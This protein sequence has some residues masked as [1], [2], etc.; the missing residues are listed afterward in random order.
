[1][2]CT[3]KPSL[4]D[5]PALTTEQASALEDLFKVL[6]NDTRLR[7]LHAIARHREICVG[8]LANELDMTPQAVSNQLQRLRGIVAT[9]RDGNS[10]YYRIV[11][12]CVLILLDRGLCL[13]EEADKRHTARRFV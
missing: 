6:A 9:R 4:R 11:D 2:K 1:M 8:D 3:P 5:R 10:I 13:L 7:L 12:Q